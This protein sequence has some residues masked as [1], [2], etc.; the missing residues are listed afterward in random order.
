MNKKN[1][2]VIDAVLIVGSLISLI[3]LTGYSRPFV[4]APLN[5]YQTSGTAVLFSIEKADILLIDDNPDFTTPDKYMI[6][7]GLKINLKPGKYY[8]KAVGVLGSEVR[9]LTINSEVKLELKKIGENYDVVNAGNVRLNVD[10]Y[11]GT[12]LIDKLNLD[13]GDAVKS[14]ADKF[15][16]GMK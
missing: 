16:G 11:N 13:V 9:T 12:K 15:I 10:I 5:D 6:K 2:W 4:I 14:D 7:D 3:F 1:I 8:W